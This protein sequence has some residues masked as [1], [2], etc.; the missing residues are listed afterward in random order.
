[1]PVVTKQRV[2]LGLLLVV[3][4][5]AAVHLYARV[6]AIIDTAPDT[7]EPV[8]TP[9]VLSSGALLADGSF[10]PL[11]AHKR[12]P[13]ED[14]VAVWDKAEWRER[15]RPLLEK[16]TPA[17]TDGVYVYPFLDLSSHGVGLSSTYGAHLILSASLATRSS[18]R[19]TGGQPPIRYGIPAIDEGNPVQSIDLK[20]WTRQALGDPATEGA[21][22]LISG[23]FRDANPGDATLTV[24]VVDRNS[25]NAE[26]KVLM[27]D[28]A[29]IDEDKGFVNLSELQRRMALKVPEALSAAG[30]GTRKA[31][32]DAGTL[33]LEDELRGV[34]D[35]L[36]AN[37]SWCVMDGIDRALQLAALFPRESAPLQA[38]SYGILGLNWT[39]FKYAH[40]F[41]ESADY[42]QRGFA[43]T[44]LALAM[45]SKPLL[46][47][48]NS[49]FSAL[50]GGQSTI[51]LA[52]AYSAKPGKGDQP[53]LAAYRAVIR[54]DFSGV[55][56]LGLLE[57]VPDWQILNIE[58]RQTWFSGAAGGFRAYFKERTAAWQNKDFYRQARIADGTSYAR[59]AGQWFPRI[60]DTGELA[61]RATLAADLTALAWALRDATLFDDLLTTDGGMSGR[62]IGAISEA[63]RTND[64]FA[65]R[66]AATEAVKEL[67]IPSTAEDVSARQLAAVEAAVRS[68]RAVPGIHRSPSGFQG[69]EFSP[70]ERINLA[71]R[72]DCLGPALMASFGAEARGRYEEAVEALHP[73]L[74]VRP[75]S[76][77]AQSDFA[78]HVNRFPTK[79]KSLE[80]Y[81]DARRASYE[82]FPL[83]TE[84][85]YRMGRLKLY[86]GNESVARAYLRQFVRADAFTVHSARLMAE[87]CRRYGYN[88][89]SI[90]YFD[91][92]TKA[93]PQRHD[94]ALSRA[95]TLC[96]MGRMRD[97][98]L[99]DIFARPSHELTGNVDFHYQNLRY[100]RD[101]LKDYPA[102]RKAAKFL[103]QH[104]R[105]RGGVAL[106]EVEHKDGNTTA[107]LEALARIDFSSLHSLELAAAHGDVAS[108]YAK[109]GRL[110]DADEHVRL[111]L[112]AEPGKGE[113]I[114]AQARTAF[115]HKDFGRA[116][117]HYQQYESAYGADANIILAM[118]K[119]HLAKGDVPTAL[120]MLEKDVFKDQPKEADP[121]LIGELLEIYAETGRP[122]R[123][124]EA[125]TLMI[126]AN[127]RSR[128]LIESALEKYK[129]MNP[130]HAE[131]I[132][133]NL[134]SIM[135]GP[136]LF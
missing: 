96:E 85:I 66:A 104:N 2:Y 19:V 31:P 106:A 16:I 103:V 10:N 18:L 70:W 56:P 129:A 99:K 26:A 12:K 65:I 107:T 132:A 43:L 49:V 22:W 54:Q 64:Y 11:P 105:W 126:H 128:L 1:M 125:M 24:V 67:R 9:I 30:I 121:E 34:A 37:E 92:Y 78:E 45:D 122:D 79:P 36:D 90:P 72:Q 83:S 32:V 82:L 69:F 28:K 113:V 41:A 97:P 73:Y 13:A 119:C 74:T 117:R 17:D 33:R 38:A 29:T 91:A 95:W 135:S 86:E 3:V 44:Q 52:E 75:T 8:P 51:E 62:E 23:V 20:Q 116:L 14:V 48:M 115:A 123:A 93:L 46:P 112:A 101:W 42:T 47:R 60:P 118:A 50:G 39:L 68:V 35:L 27:E 59:V 4:G 109:I 55:L 63:A 15:Y 87:V 114:L 136:A 110:D 102:A 57:V 127:R 5:W 40:G 84:A 81:R 108:M 120:E 7:P 21:R 111:A 71:Y 6:H 25:P 58:A 131:E 76:A 80:Y 124:K 98:A 134:D 100:L 89:A 130:A 94:I 88:A 53:E 61:F 77:T 133:T